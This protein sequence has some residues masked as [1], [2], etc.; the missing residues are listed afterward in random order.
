M[1]ICLLRTSHL[2]KVEWVDPVLVIV[3]TR[4]WN[5]PTIFTSFTDML[6][7]TSARFAFGSP[8]AWITLTKTCGGVH[9]IHN[10][11]IPPRLPLSMW[12]E[13]NVPMQTFYFNPISPLAN[14]NPTTGN[15]FCLT[16]TRW[17]LQLLQI[18]PVEQWRKKV[19]VTSMTI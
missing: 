16:V 13:S 9:L 14:P 19:Q 8:V 17:A 3:Q 5:R 4:R 1:S 10:L 12:R 11:I 6:L 18:S 7:N 2:T 15:L